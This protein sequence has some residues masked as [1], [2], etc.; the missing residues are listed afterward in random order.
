MASITCTNVSGAKMITST[1]EGVVRP[2]SWYRLRPCL[3]GTTHSPPDVMA[4]LQGSY[5]YRDGQRTGG[6]GDI[7]KPK[8][9]E[10]QLTFKFCSR[11]K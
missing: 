10:A 7:Y 5:S 2:Q 6:E 11:G 3:R 8:Q 1:L 9:L 4:H